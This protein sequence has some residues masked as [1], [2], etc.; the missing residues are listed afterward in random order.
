MP[1][2]ATKPFAASLLALV[3][4]SGCS[5]L[6]SNDNFL[7]VITP[8]RVEIVQ[9]NVVTKEQIAAVKPGM[10]RAEVRDI[11]GSPLVTDAFHPQRWDYVFTIKR[12]GTEPQNRRVVVLFDGDAMKS[13]DAP[14]DL[15]GEREFVTAITPPK[16]AAKGTPPPL[17]LTEAQRQA[18]PAPTRVEANTEAAPTGPTR[19]YPPL[20]ATP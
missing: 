18:L 8:Y 14:A 15:P 13:V 20:E 5:S 9:G 10:S 12:Q 3:T 4:L 17:E 2:I 7:G 16:L 11:L 1:R 6:Q 19:T